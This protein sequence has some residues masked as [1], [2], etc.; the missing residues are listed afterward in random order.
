MIFK[1]SKINKIFSITASK[2]IE[3]LESLEDTG[4]EAKLIVKS[5]EMVSLK[6][7]IS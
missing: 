7:L 1:I 4:K 6:K 2:E 5:L 3:K